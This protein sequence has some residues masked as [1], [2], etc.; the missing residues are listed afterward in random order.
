MLAFSLLQDITI[1]KTM[2]SPP[3]GV[4][5]VMEA[6]CVIKGI[7]PDRVPDPSG[8]GKKIEDYWGPSKK[9]LGDMKFLESLVNFDKDNIPAPLIKQIRT[10]YTPNP[11][12]DPDKV[13]VASTA[14]EGLCRWV[15]A[16]ESYDK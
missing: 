6:I 15:R 2:K 12:F 5:L 1:V 14:C 11:D 10:K 4:R 8:S 9:V 16:M 3:N 13:K 7:K